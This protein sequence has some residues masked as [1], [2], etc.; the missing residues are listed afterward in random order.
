M[1]NLSRRIKKGA[2]KQYLSK[3][4]K[5]ETMKSYLYKRALITS[6]IAV[7]SLTNTSVAQEP[8]ASNYRMLFKFNTEKQ[9]DNTRLLEVSFIGRHKKNKKDK[10]PVYD[11]EIK[12]FN[13]INE[14]EVLL[15]ASKTS[16]EGIAQVTFAED[17]SFITETDGTINFI[18]RF[19][20]SDGIDAQEEELSI[21]DLHLELNLKEVDSTRLV[22]VHAF[23]RD[24]LGNKYPVSETDI[25]I[26][27]GGMLSKMKLEES[28]IEEG[29]FE[30]EFP[31]DIPGD[32]NGNISIYSIIEDHDDFG[33]VTK[34]ET[35]NWGI[36]NKKPKEHANMLW[37][38]AAPLWMYIVLTIMLVGVWA[39]YVYTIINLI[40]L[41]KEGDA[42]NLE[43]Q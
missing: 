25:I 30:F 7:L 16:K 42:I 41:K 21:K 19:E 28:T 3:Y 38:H 11:A 22:Q 29:T 36:L 6:F 13:R 17:H 35:I 14:Q 20:S 12:F 18:A 26:S 8:D 4:E 2:R 9:S 15:G 24:S 43:T 33:N 23:T 5:L 37:S 40:K 39:N 32:V 10:L 27:I 31:A 34:M 1:K